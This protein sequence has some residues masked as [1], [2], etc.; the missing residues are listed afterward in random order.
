M[1]VPG[2]Q[3][4]LARRLPEFLAAD[5]V[6]HG[7]PVAEPRR[8][9]ETEKHRALVRMTKLIDRE[10]IGIYHGP[11]LE[12]AFEGLDRGAVDISVLRGPVVPVI[13]I[14]Q[15]FKRGYF[16]CRDYVTM[17]APYLPRHGFF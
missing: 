9:R 4:G 15:D 8:S 16:D 5:A 7:L 12:I 11:R 1:V 13:Q 2:R 6:Q 14:Q 3:I 17:I 10:R